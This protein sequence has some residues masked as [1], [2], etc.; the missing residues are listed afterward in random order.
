MKKPSGYETSQEETYRF[1]PFHWVS[2]AGGCA[3]V[4]GLVRTL[5]FQIRQG[6]FPWG[7]EAPHSRQ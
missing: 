5:K 2:V 7:G 1:D 4:A 6:A 3:L